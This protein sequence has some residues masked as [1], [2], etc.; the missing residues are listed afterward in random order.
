MQREQRH[1]NPAADEHCA[2]KRCTDAVGIVRAK[3]LRGEAGRAHA[4]EIAAEVEGVEDQSADG[5]GTKEMRLRKV[6][7]DGGVNGTEQR[8][9]QVGD[10][11]RPGEV[12]KPPVPLVIP[13][14]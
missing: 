10:D 5:D 14:Q 6:T 13:N 9:R 4:Q 12:P 2:R 1:G 8:D 11:H 3:I 7:N